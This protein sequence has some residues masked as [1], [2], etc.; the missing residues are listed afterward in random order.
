MHIRDLQLQM[1]ADGELKGRQLHKIEQ[2]LEHCDICRNRL[3]HL[4]EEEQAWRKLLQQ[5]EA[6]TKVPPEWLDSWMQA[7][8]RHREERKQKLQLAGLLSLGLASLLWLAAWLV[9]K[10]TWWWAIASQLW[11]SLE[12]GLFWSVVSR[13][14]R[15]VLAK[16]E[17][18]PLALYPLL[19]YALMLWCLVYLNM[20]KWRGR[21]R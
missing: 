20:R 10:Q 9:G 4:Q 12:M 16:G 3:A 21:E 11:A 5:E 1:Y 6:E 13:C 7:A 17:W 19:L 14:W 15:W 18:E 8:V 2:H